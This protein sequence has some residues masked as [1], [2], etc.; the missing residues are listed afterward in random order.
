MI[1]CSKLG[2]KECETRND[3]VEK[4]LHR[5]LC[6]KSKLGHTTKWYA[7]QQEFVIENETNIIL[8]DLEVPVV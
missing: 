1:E 5:E 2:Q 7:H 4:F 8:R 6:K 3:W